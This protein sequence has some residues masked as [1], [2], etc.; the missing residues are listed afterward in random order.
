MYRDVEVLDLVS[1]RS[2]TGGTPVFVDPHGRRARWTSVAGR[3]AGGATVL[4][5]VLVVASLV[6]AP[7]V[8]RVGLPS[9]GPA[10]RT[11]H[12]TSAVTLPAS[13][14][15]QAPPILGHPAKG[16]TP[17]TAVTGAGARSSVV[18]SSPVT[19]A[20]TAV[21]TAAPGQTRTSTTTTPLRSVATTTPPGRSGT[22]PGKH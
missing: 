4:Y 9:V 13:A 10:P 19:S 14:P 22:A 7:W 11:V 2:S 16:T 3:L 15:R 20:R 21:T 6:G 5:L 12:A 18:T 17:T 1:S 8:P